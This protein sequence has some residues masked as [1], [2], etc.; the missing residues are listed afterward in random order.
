MLAAEDGSFELAPCQAPNRSTTCAW[1]TTAGQPVLWRASRTSTV[2]RHPY[3][4]TGSNWANYVVKVDVMLPRTVSAGLT[5]RYRAAKAP[6][7]RGMFN[8]Y[9]SDVNTDGTFTLTLVSNGLATSTVSGQH[10]VRPAS[11]VTLAWSRSPPGPGTPRRCPYRAP[12]SRP[13][14]TDSKPPRCRTPR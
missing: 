1:Q 5:G 8:T 13:A 9:L 14:W 2:P 10:V 11:A 3:A 12:P 6:P 7:A 4:I